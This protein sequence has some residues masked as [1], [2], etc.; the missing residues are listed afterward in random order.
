MNV[1]TYTDVTRVAVMASRV[2]HTLAP[3]PTT[4]RGGAVSID[5]F[6]LARDPASWTWMI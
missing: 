3:T 6:T 2:R 1:N 4:F 5:G